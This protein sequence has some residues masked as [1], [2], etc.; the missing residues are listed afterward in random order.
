M[1]QPKVWAGAF[2]GSLIVVEVDIDRALASAVV[3]VQLDAIFIAVFEI[4]GNPFRDI[5]G[6]L[7][8]PDVDRHV[9]RAGH[10]EADFAVVAGVHACDGHLEQVGTI[11]AFAIGIRAEPCHLAVGY[12]GFFWRFRAGQNAVDVDALFNG[13]LGKLDIDFTG[14]DGAGMVSVSLHRA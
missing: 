12:I 9:A 13:V 2:R 10:I 11:V 1:V 3:L 6:G 7:R 14:L 5:A 4:G 8:Q